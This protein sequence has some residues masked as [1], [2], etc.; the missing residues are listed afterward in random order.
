MYLTLFCMF[1]KKR[2]ALVSDSIA[3]YAIIVENKLTVYYILGYNSE[4]LKINKNEK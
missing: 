1:I 2:F 3:S 4:S